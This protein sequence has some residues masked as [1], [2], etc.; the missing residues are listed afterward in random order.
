MDEPFLYY[1]WKY[2]KFTKRPLTLEGG[3][4][5]QVFKTGFQNHDS[6]PDFEEA[7]I[8]IGEL[9]WVGQ[10]EMH[11]KASDWLQHKHQH[12]P[13]YQNV[14]LHVVWENNQSITVDGTTL[15]TL[16]LKEYVDLEVVS[17]YEN[18][19]K[20]DHEIL[21][22]D[23][24]G[25]VSTIVKQSMLDRMMVE[26][27]ETK[28][29]NLL[30]T[31]KS[32]ITDWEAATYHILCTSFGFS[33]NKFAFEHLSRM[34]PY[35]SLKK[36]LQN[37]H[38]TEAILFGQAGF[39]AEASNEDSYK[40]ALRKEFEYLKKKFDLKDPMTRTQWKF[41]KM[42]P[43]NFPTI[44]IAQLASLLHTHPKLFS[45]II[46]ADTTE[47][48]Q[49]IQVEMNPYWQT[50][51]DFGKGR[52]KSKS[53]GASSIENLLVNAV[54]PLLA[55]YA[56]YVGNE[57]YMQK[58]CDLVQSLKPENNRITRKWSLPNA[59]AYDSQALIQLYKAYCKPKQCLQCNIGI[60][61]LK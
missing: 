31:L 44:R 23:K 53:M 50:H 47:I 55:A 29:N 18:H 37:P 46:Q 41:S 40:V 38:Q 45:K 34:I 54:A 1:I 56:Q 7:H 17:K 6:G 35:E 21:C 42:R 3:E 32:S 9:E 39:L 27:L 16:A 10:V 36:V 26:R 49:L 30:Q 25:S 19:L 61:L 28:A 14:V 15:P 24:L 58:A 52:R 2:Q 51:Y 13:A 22:A 12:D 60:D 48:K 33:T 43:A 5:L 11:V 20:S 8:K 4:Q 59:S 57:D